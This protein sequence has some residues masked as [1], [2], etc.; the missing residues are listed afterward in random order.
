ML[1]DDFKPVYDVSDAV[2][3]VVNADVATRHLLP[4]GATAGPAPYVVVWCDAN[5]DH[6]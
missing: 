3:T 2:A 1:V 6:R 4:L 5:G